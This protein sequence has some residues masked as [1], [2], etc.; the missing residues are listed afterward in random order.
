MGLLEPASRGFLGFILGLLGLM[1]GLLAHFGPPGACWGS[2]WASW[3]LLGFILSLWGPPGDHFGPPGA[4]WS[5]CW[6]SQGSFFI[7]WGSV[8][9]SSGLLG[10]ILGLLGLILGLMKPRG[11]HSGSPE[12]HVGPPGALLG[13]SWRSQ[14]APG[15]L[16]G[17]AW[18]LQ[19]RSR[20]PSRRPPA[21]E[22]DFGFILGS[23]LAPCLD[24]QNLENHCF[25]V[26]RLHFS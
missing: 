7:S 5:V 24:S 23:I 17:A 2:S 9:T 20:R 8:R 13:L 12:A 26:E 10:L 6:A 25:R 15:S 21:Q 16:W 3:G 1:L 22:L 14:G 19:N 4:S 11:I 18:G